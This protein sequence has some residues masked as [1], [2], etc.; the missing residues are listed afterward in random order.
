MSIS[1]CGWFAMRT[2]T[3]AAERGGRRAETASPTGESLVLRGW[4]SVGYELMRRLCLSKGAITE[5]CVGR[6]WNPASVANNSFPGSFVLS[7]A[8]TVGRHGSSLNRIWLV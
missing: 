3:G 1:N 7:R 8:R 6:Y 5:G 4:V 2:A